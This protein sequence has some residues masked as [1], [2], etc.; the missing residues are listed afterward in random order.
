VANTHLVKCVLTPAIDGSLSLNNT[1][2]IIDSSHVLFGF[3]N[4][5]GNFVNN[6][7]LFNND[8]LR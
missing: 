5:P 1:N 3:D 4:I 2:A 7:W 6:F 8:R